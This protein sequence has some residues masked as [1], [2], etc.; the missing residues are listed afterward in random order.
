MAARI[1]KPSK[2]AMSSGVAK[3]HD[4]VLEFEPEIP[5]TIEP[6]MGYTSSRDTTRQVKLTFKTKEEA[7]GYAEREGLAYRVFEPSEKKRPAISYSDNF[8]ADR[9]APWTH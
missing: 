7:V 3:T 9:R 6:L 4:W 1:Y 2:T 8:R 5:R